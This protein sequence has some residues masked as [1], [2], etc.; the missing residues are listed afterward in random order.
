MSEIK[1]NNWQEVITNFLVSKKNEKIAN[2]LGSKFLKDKDKGVNQYLINEISKENKNHDKLIEIINSKKSSQQNKLEFL[3]YKHDNLTHL[4]KELNIDISQALKQEQEEIKIINEN[5][6]PRNWVLDNIKNFSNVEYATH[7]IKLTHSKI[8]ECSSILDKTTNIRDYVLS[9]S[10]LKNKIIDGAVTGNQFAPIFQFF[11]L[12]FNGEKLST[13]LKNPNNEILTSFAE[14]DNELKEWKQQISSVLNLESG[15]LK[16]HN[17]AKQI[18]FP[19]NNQ[20]YHLLCNIKSSSMAQSIYETIKSYNDKYYK[21]K[22]KQEKSGYFYISNEIKS[23]SKT[24]TIS[25]TQSNH[26]NASQ[27]NG[28]RGGGIKL[29][30]TQPPIWQSKLKPPINKNSMFD[31]F[32]ISQN[33]KDNISYISNFLVRF[34]KVNL[35]IK[36]PEKE[37]HFIRWVNNII[38]DVLYYITSIQSL[39]SGW[40]NSEDIKLKTEYQYLLDAYREDKEFQVA[41]ENT[42]WQDAICKDFSVWLNQRIENTNKEFT[43]QKIY[44]K[45]W[46]KQL[47]E[48]LREHEEG[49]KFNL[50]IGQKL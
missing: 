21:L 46:E 18:Y 31:N 9:T 49:I 36:D 38:D 29:F 7:V 26:S 17:L 10:N 19:I 45:I 20:Q 1:F 30:S 47:S 33:T 24:A 16:S 39:S 37:K 2:L 42:N 28:K 34:N 11:E 25:T 43:R 12:E 3:I 50:N 23:F 14:N 35:S 22:E 41:R 15:T 40:S 8:N 4:A 48:A 32:Y 5:Y 6:K 27:L 13:V 44:S